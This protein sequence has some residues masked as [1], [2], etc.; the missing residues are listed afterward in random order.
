M[1]LAFIAAA[2]DTTV[3]ELARD[4]LAVVSAWTMV[5]LGLAF[6]AI[7]VV[8]LLVLAELR[9]LS[10]TWT[11]FWPPRASDPNPSWSTPTAPPATSIMSRRSCGPRST[12]STEWS[13]A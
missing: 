3:V 5:G 1:P 8:L 13:R 7:L 6:L 10:R 4:G 9:M 12:G 11:G 2:Q